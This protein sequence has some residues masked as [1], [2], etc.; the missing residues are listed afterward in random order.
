M[1]CPPNSNN[2]PLLEMRQ[3]ITFHIV[4]ITKPAL[5]RQ[6]KKRANYPVA[7]AADLPERLPS[8]GLFYA[9]RKP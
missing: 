4:V 9:R 1:V 3:I 5:G 7:F 8:R 2:L 6:D